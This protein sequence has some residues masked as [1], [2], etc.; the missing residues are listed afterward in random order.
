MKKNWITFTILLFTCVLVMGTIP[1]QA[2]SPDE[3][4]IKNLIQTYA[5]TWNKK[6]VKGFMSIFH[7]DAKIMY[8]PSYTVVSKEEYAKVLPGII[9]DYSGVGFKDTDIK[10][11][12]NKAA[13]TAMQSIGG[14]DIPIAWDLVKDAGKWYIMENSY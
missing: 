10:I 6:D 7:K 4:A 14:F 8:G 13:V 2:S 9:S 5:D 1:V 11:T 3:Q 12:D